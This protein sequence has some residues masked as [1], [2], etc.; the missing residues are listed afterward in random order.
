MQCWKACEERCYYKD[1]RLNLIKVEHYFDKKVKSTFHTV[2]IRLASS[3]FELEHVEKEKNTF[4]TFAN[5]MV[6]VLAILFGI[7][8]SSF[9]TSFTFVEK[10]IASCFRKPNAIKMLHRRRR[11]HI[12][13]ANNLSHPQV[14]QLEPQQMRRK[15]SSYLPRLWQLLCLFANL[16]QTY[17][18]V[19]E[20]V[21]YTTTVEM[22]IDNNC[23]QIPSVTVVLQ[24]TYRKMLSR[25]DVVNP[26]LVCVDEELRSCQNISQLDIEISNDYFFFKIN[27]TSFREKYAT[28][29][30]VCLPNGT[31]YYITIRKPGWIISSSDTIVK[32]T[33]NQKR[34]VYI[35]EK[36]TFNALPHPYKTDCKLYQKE[37][38]RHGCFRKCVRQRL[39][40]LCNINV[41]L[42]DTPLALQTAAD[43]CRRTVLGKIHECNCGSPDCEMVEYQIMLSRMFSLKN[44]SIEECDEV[45]VR[46]PTSVQ[47]VV[48]SLRP[49]FSFPVLLISIGNSSAFWI[50]FSFYNFLNFLENAV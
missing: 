24:T 50:G 17:E 22:H 28:R 20:Y 31:P 10:K 29:F 9:S 23:G 34:K 26:L 33:M 16:Y 5:N 39:K 42:I 40:T 25:R 1:C 7:S 12:F 13:N 44:H 30:K 36:E 47:F 43:T 6:A 19:G 8:V 11:H 45:F 18:I 41:T 49:K 21:N 38:G 27:D 3:P 35:F 48:R 32:T 46:C 15:L 2:A 4:S 14:L 37:G